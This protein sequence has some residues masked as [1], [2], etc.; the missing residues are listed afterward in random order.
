M[1][2]DVGYLARTLEVTVNTR[3]S[4]VLSNTATRRLR[5]VLARTV[6][7]SC[8]NESA[9]STQ[10]EL[11]AHSSIACQ[12]VDHNNHGCSNNPYLLSMTV[13]GD[14]NGNGNDCFYDYDQPPHHSQWIVRQVLTYHL[15]TITHSESK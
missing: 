9:M 13:T 10:Q 5:V 3:I 7:R 6:D 15:L 14:S 12:C 8:H 11:T 4:M 1:I 2:L